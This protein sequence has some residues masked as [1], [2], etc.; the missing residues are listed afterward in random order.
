MYDFAFLTFARRLYCFLKE[1]EAPILLFRGKRENDF[2]F[3]KKRGEYFAFLMRETVSD[4]MG[5]GSCG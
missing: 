4:T 5:E 3:W 2:A 1:N